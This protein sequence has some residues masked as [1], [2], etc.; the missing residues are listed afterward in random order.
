MWLMNSEYS[1][2]RGDDL[3]ARMLGGEPDLGNELLKECWGGYPVERIRALLRSDVESA[4]KSGAFIA[5][6]L[7]ELSRPLLND[8][9]PLLNHPDTWVRS[10]AIDAVNLAA[11]VDEAEIVARAIER[12]TDSERS[13]RGSAFTLLAAAEREQLEASCGYI[14]DIDVKEALRSVL[15]EEDTVSS[16][17]IRPRLADQSRLVRLFG[18]LSAARIGDR[19]ADDLLAAIEA[20]DEEIQLFAFRVARG[21]RLVPSTLFEDRAGA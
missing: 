1:S 8:V 18:L 20:D 19:G 6:E 2:E 5:S 17:E 14:D 11:T 12:I 13:I 3:L 16:A 4:V 15:D 9:E 10:D 7:A 21:R